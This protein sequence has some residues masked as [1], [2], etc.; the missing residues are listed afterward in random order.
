MKSV[1]LPHGSMRR[2]EEVANVSQ[3]TFSTFGIKPNILERW[4]TSIPFAP[5]T[6]ALSQRV[7]SVGATGGDSSL[8]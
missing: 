5:W 8:P 1:C 2:E 4:K 7:W 3:S 6:S